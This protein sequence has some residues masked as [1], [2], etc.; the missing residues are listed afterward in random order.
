MTIRAIQLFNEKFGDQWHREVEDRWLYRDFKAHPNWR[1]KWIS[2]DCAA[3][4]PA[5]DRIYLGITSFDADIFKAYDRRTGRFVDLGF[6]RIA[7]SFDAKFHRSLELGDDGCLYAA[8]A[9]LHDADQYQTAP[10]GAIVKYD[11]KNGEISKLITPLPHIYIQSIALDRRRKMIYCMCFAPE[12]LAGFNLQTNEVTDYGLIGAGVGGMAQGENLCLDDRGRAWCGWQLTR[13]WQ[14][15]PGPDANRLCCIDPDR[16]R[17][18]FFQSGLPRPDGKHGTLKVEG[19]FNLGDGHLYASGGNGSIYRINIE[20]AEAR[21]LFTP[22]TDRRS[23][24]TS[25]ALGPDGCAYGVTGRD[26]HCQL[27]RFDFRNDRFALIGRIREEN[28]D[29]FQAHHVVF[30]D[31]GTLYVCENDVP[32]RSAYL[33]EISGIF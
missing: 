1:Q 32:H 33:W 30:A 20:T 8:I 26:G 10:G 29:C 28:E 13:A 22:V 7:E 23:R 3:Y 5:D 17:I 19:L 14:G 9:L 31:D 11:P 2:F 18:L 6:S 15:N 12:K 21:H 16:G 24:L 4:N 25:L 27:L